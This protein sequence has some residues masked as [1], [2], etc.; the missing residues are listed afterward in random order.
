MLGR[1]REEMPTKGVERRER[2]RVSMIDRGPGGRRG[3]DGGSPV[4]GSGPSLWSCFLC[5]DVT[6]LC[7]SSSPLPDYQQI[8]QISQLVCVN[9]VLV[10][11]EGAQF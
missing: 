2:T 5:C 4:V 6:L 9:G 10:E 8:L 7:I 3:R 1:H 11:I